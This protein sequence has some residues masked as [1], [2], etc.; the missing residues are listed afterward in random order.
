MIR[1]KLVGSACVPNDGATLKL[2]QRDA[3]FSLR[4]DNLELMNSRVH[5]SEEALAHFACAALK[6]VQAASILIGGLGM[7]FTLRTVLDELGSNSK[8]TVAELVPEVVQWNREWLGSLS[9]H[10]LEDRRVTVYEEDV[11]RL[12]KQKNASFDAILLDVDNGPEG[13]TQQS[14]AWLY[15]AKGL[16]A[17]SAALKAEGVLAVWSA[18][19]SQAFTKSLYKAGFKV[20][21]ERVRARGNRGAWH[22]IWL[23]EKG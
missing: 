20:K 7:G 21:E 19:P 1:W 22:T 12:L 5:G 3:E 6:N 23:A 8:I 9:E 14:N 16:A 17:A 18:H 11:A 13:L 15:S 2:Y 4:L 10:P